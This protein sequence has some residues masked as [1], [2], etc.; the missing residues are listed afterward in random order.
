MADGKVQPAAMSIDQ[1]VLLLKH[2]D[3]EI[4]GQAERLFGGGVSQNRQEVAQRYRAALSVAASATDGRRVFERTCAQCHRIEQ[5]GHAVGPD[6]SD[7]RGRSRLALLHDILDPNAKV[8]PAYTAYS[9]VTLDAQ[10]FTGLMVNETAEAVV[11][12]MPEGKE[13]T[14]GRRDIGEIHA[15]PISLM[16][17]GIEQDVT[18]H[19]MADLLEFLKPRSTP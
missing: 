11:L 19:Q 7:V 14:I 17:E 4:R 18:V 9:V 15:S 13:R 1:R 2:R 12:R 16:P 8:E 10:V 6:L 5:R 3:A